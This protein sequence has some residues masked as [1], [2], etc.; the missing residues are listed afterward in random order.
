MLCEHPES[1]VARLWCLMIELQ[2]EVGVTK[3]DTEFYYKLFS[4]LPEECREEIK[5]HPEETAQGRFGPTGD[6]GSTG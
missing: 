5:E 4:V 1:V 3:T 2:M 6:A